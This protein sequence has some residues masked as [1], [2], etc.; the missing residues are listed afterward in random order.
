MLTLVAVLVTLDPADSRPHL[1]QGPGITL[2]ESFNVQMGVYLVES[3]KS[4]RLGILDPQSAQEVFGNPAY[5]P[6]HPPLGRLWL[7][8][9]H[10]ISRSV[11]PVDSGDNPFV[12]IHARAGSAFAFALTAFLVGVF[13]ARHWGSLA[14]V[15]SSVSLAVMPRLSGHAHLA[16]LETFM[17]LTWTVAILGTI[18][19]WARRDESTSH[20]TSPS[21]SNVA[22]K[23][24][25]PGDKAA[26]LCGLFIGLALL[27]KMQAVLLPPLL[28]V[29]AFWHWRLSA[30]RPLAVSGI[31]TAIVF[32]V[33]WPWL[34]PD[35]PGHLTE[36]FGRTTGRVSLNVWYLGQVF[37]DVDV[38]WHYPWVMTFV[39]VPVGILLLAAVGL[40]GARRGILNDP[41]TSL[42]VGSIIAPLFL[43]SL[44]GVAVYDGARLFLV[45]FPGI[46]LLAGFGVSGLRDWLVARKWP[47]K[48]L[49]G[50]LLATQIVGIVAT[51]PYN[52]SYYNVAVGG[53]PGA[54]RLGFE[55]SYWGDS[56]SREFLSELVRAVPE[57]A[58]VQVAPLLHQFQ[59]AEIERQVPILANGNSP[60]G[61]RVWLIAADNPLAPYRDRR[62]SVGT[63]SASIPAEFLAVFRRRAD[64][65]QSKLLKEAGWELVNSQTCQ[66]VIVASLWR[67]SN[68]AASR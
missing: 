17:G 52:L 14:G 51:T 43:F 12:T 27:T 42:L 56:F 16:S 34:W 66:G 15:T 63:V 28:T 31:T 65:P 24:E 40:W 29:W 35:L 67:R 50:I 11:A 25:P 64:T 18:H 57:N 45:A 54:E 48:P 55:V 5:N 33:G 2:D 59:L 32:V 9:F 19:L 1:P 23:S 46:A 3:L 8:V 68:L 7:G 6:D 41:T 61:R 47:H 26:I 53:T 13:A 62:Q 30:F 37:K 60:T 38:P 36:Y 39:T 58:I 4:Y 22:L 10:E 44:P 21:D 20:D 49:L